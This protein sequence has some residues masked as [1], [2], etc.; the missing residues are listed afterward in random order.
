VADLL[1]ILRNIGQ[2]IPDRI[3]LPGLPGVSAITGPIEARIERFEQ[4]AEE[5]GVKAEQYAYAQLTLQAISTAAMV[6]IF[7]VSL[8]RSKSQGD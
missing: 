2:K 6:G 1:D 7:L 5:I 4:K 3:S 8:S